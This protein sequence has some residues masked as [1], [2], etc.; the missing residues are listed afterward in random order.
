[1]IRL[2]KPLLRNTF[3]FP[4]FSG[5]PTPSVRISQ[6]EKYFR[7]VFFHDNG[8]SN[9]LIGHPFSEFYSILDT[10]AG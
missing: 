8:Q 2:T 6:L 5:F 7:V 4:A 9:F 3:D 1:M 10:L